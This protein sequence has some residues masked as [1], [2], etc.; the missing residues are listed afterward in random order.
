MCDLWRPLVASC[1]LLVTFG[2]P[3]T[4][5]VPACDLFVTSQAPCSDQFVETQFAGEN[6]VTYLQPLGLH[7]MQPAPAL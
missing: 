3:L 2:W 6:V 7:A 1:D 5:P 4:Q